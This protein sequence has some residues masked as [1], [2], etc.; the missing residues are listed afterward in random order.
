V[1]TNGHGDGEREAGDGEARWVLADE[2]GPAAAPPPPVVHTA[3]SGGVMLG[4]GAPAH[5]GDVPW[6]PPAPDTVFAPQGPYEHVAATPPAVDYSTP[7][8]PKRS[9]GKVIGL[10]VGCVAIVAAGVF[11]ITKIVGGDEDNGGADSPVGAVELLV[12]SAN[13]QDLLGVIDAVLPSEREAIGE[14]LLDMIEEA[15][16]IE[17]LSPDADP[18]QISGFGIDYDLTYGEPQQL[19]DDLMVVPVDGTNNSVADLDELPIGALLTDNGVDPSGQTEGPGEREVHG[20]IVTVQRDGRWYVS[21]GY[22]LGELARTSIGEPDWPA[23]DEGTTPKGAETPEGA[24]DAVF[25]ALEKTSLGDL[26][27]VLNPNE[28]EVLQRVSPWWLDNAQDAIDG[29]LDGGDWSVEIKDPEYTVTKDGDRAVVSVSSLE[30]EF[31]LGESGKIVFKDGCVSMPD[32]GDPVCVGNL[33]SSEVVD[34]QLEAFG[35]GDVSDELK[36]VQTSIMEALADLDQQGIV[37]TKV[38][39]QWYV[40]PIGS[41]TKALLDVMKALTRTELDGIIES[42]EDAIEAFT[43]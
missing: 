12:D 33:D 11:A 23:L 40:S 34:D 2:S 17:L 22:S 26:L 15:K 31:D 20:R 37:V 3:A 42:V 43:N 36:D 6:M 9:K 39:G 4:G 18:K 13:A 5:A 28:A 30:A 8:A 14:P 24:V 41:T 32:G 27:A 7:P 21:L 1:S 35:L 16:R 19:A 25:A 38:D 10:V 29:A